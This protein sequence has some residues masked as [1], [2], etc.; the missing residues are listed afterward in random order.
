MLKRSLIPKLRQRGVEI[1]ADSKLPLPDEAV[2]E[3]PCGLKWVI[4]GH[5]FELGAFSYGVSGYWFAVTI[6]RY[7]SFGEDVQIG[8]QNHPI[9]W[10]STSPS[11]YL[12]QKLFNVGTDFPSSD[13]YHAYTPPGNRP[14]PTRIKQTVIGN[15][16]WIGQG[17]IINAGITIGTGAIIAAGSVV[18]NDVPNYMIVGGNPAKVIRPRFEEKLALDL[19]QSQWWR[20]TPSQLQS[21]DISDPKAFLAAFSNNHSELI[22]YKPEKIKI[23]E[24]R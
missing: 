13:D 19:L 17:A 7:C 3:P 4:P 2:F 14:G 21:F 1:F 12:Q 18:T 8:R 24:L 23:S 10:V 5:T 9:G 22:A 16:V 20:F 11:F 15:D 6:G